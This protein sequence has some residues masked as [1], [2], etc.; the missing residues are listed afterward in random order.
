M[1]VVA[2]KIYKDR[3]EMGCDSQVTYGE[4]KEDIQKRYGLGK[5]LDINSMLI[6]YV[7][8]LGEGQRMMLY[9]MKTKP[10]GNRISDIIEWFL[11]FVDDCKKKDFEFKPFNNW[12]LVYRQKVFQISDDLD[13]FEVKNYCAMG[14][15][16][17]HAIPL[18]EMGMS[19]REAI[20]MSCKLDIYCSKPVKIYSV[21]KNKNH[22]KKDIK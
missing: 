21:S 2:V 3:I 9:A 1:S 7:G 8:F 18:L 22:E 19:I 20:E 11:G 5:I 15:G 13:V 17:F 10:A 16:K 14:C 12:I 4:Y 6:G